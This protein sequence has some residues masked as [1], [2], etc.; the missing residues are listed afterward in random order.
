MSDCTELKRFPV[1]IISLIYMIRVSI[2]IAWVFFFFQFAFPVCRVFIRQL[3]LESQR[4]K[5]IVGFLFFMSVQGLHLS[6]KH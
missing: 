6:L 5:K 1:C 4:L 3:M 2:L